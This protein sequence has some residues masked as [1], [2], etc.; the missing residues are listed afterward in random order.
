[1]NNLLLKM[2]R[3]LAVQNQFSQTMANDG[4]GSSSSSGSGSSIYDTTTDTSSIESIADFAATLELILRKILGP[5]LMVIGVVAVAYA[6]YLGVMY[7]KAEDA[8]KRKEVQGR[9]IGAIIGAVIIVAAATVCLAI[10]WS[11]LYFS[12]Q[13]THKFANTNGDGWCD[14]CGHVDSHPFHKAG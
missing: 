10:N 11:D 7:A 3:L 2:G 5:V 9:L 12:F 6:I 14:F 1:M 8:I 4:G 13:G